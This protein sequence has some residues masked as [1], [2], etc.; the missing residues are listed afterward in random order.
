MVSSPPPKHNLEG[1][2]F[3]DRGDP[4]TQKINGEFW[5]EM[6]PHSLQ[7]EVHLHTPPEDIATHV[8]N[9][10]DSLLGTTAMG[11]E[12]KEQHSSPFK[13]LHKVPGPPPPPMA[14][15]IEEHTSTIVH[16]G[17]KIAAASAD[18]EIPHAPEANEQPTENVNVNKNAPGNASVI[19]ESA[20]EAGDDE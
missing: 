3:I 1:T 15:I 13:R 18:E 4:P 17:N 6:H 7:G 10:P 11:V 20:Q 16:E 12:D 14:S 5:E 8:V 19:E 9:T 2:F